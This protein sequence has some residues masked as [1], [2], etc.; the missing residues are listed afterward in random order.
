[1][2]NM[3]KDELI[4]LYFDGKLNANQKTLFDDLMLTDAEFKAQVEFEE[5]TKK[6]IISIKKDN[7]KRK[8]E[9]IESPKKRFNYYTI[10][11]AASLIVALGIFS[12]LQ[13]T[14]TVSNEQLFAEYFQPY[15]NVIAPASRGD[16]HTNTKTEAFAYYD[17]RNY[18]VASEKFHTLFNTTNTSYYLFYEAIC[19][20]QL[21]NTQMAINLFEQHKGF[22]DK[23]V[24]HRNWYL[25]LAYLKIDNVKDAK[26]L[27]QTITAKKS[28]KHKAAENILKKIK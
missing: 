19:E 13:P 27:L 20:L 7:L 8:L 4:A 14:E 17:A 11:I 3:K 26:V 1:M 6:A 15:A 21:G 23:L 22:E 28:Y 18:K 9:Q 16:E 25:A 24:T 10:A 2:H 5:H 12:L